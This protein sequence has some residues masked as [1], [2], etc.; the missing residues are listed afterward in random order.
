MDFSTAPPD[1][2]QGHCE[3]K[4][5]PRWT[6]PSWLICEPCLPT[7]SPAAAPAFCATCKGQEQQGS[8]VQQG[9]LCTKGD[10]LGPQQD[11][12]LSPSRWQLQRG[13]NTLQREPLL[14]IKVSN[15]TKRKVIF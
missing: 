6:C 7:H 2:Q 12:A 9:T 13:A 14:V 1:A 3:S 8:R 4:G 15:K 5:E 11:W 10:V